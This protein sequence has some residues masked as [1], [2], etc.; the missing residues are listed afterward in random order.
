LFHGKRHPRELAAGDVGRF[1]EHVAQSEKEPLR[2][3]EQAHEAL[4]FLYKDL[5]HLNLGELP[6]PQ[7]PKAVGSTQYAEGSRQGALAAI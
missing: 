1:L 7:P 4:T 2:R 3:L 6:L 5:L